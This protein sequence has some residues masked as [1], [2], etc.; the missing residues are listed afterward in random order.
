[1]GSEYSTGFTGKQRLRTRNSLLSVILDPT[2]T[3]DIYQGLLSGKIGGDGCD[4]QMLGYLF[5]QCR[6]HSCGC[7]FCEAIPGWMLCPE[8]VITE[9]E[10]LF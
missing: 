4:C 2:P 5:E 9:E 3:A 7:K 6:D 1:M 10:D 8:L